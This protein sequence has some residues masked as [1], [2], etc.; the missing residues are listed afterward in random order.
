[1]S[2]YNRAWRELSGTLGTCVLAVPGGAVVRED[3]AMVFV[4][5]VGVE[6]AADDKHVKLVALHSKPE[7]VPEPPRVEAHHG[8][9]F[10][11]KRPTHLV[12]PRCGQKRILAYLLVNEDGGHEHTRYVCTFWPSNKGLAAMDPNRLPRCGWEGWTVPASD[13]PKEDS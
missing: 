2:R 13:Q 1:M 12:C 9:D 8:V 7:P 5:G 11:N 4:P 3:G 10:D 6:K